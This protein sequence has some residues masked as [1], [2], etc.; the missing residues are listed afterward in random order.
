M[1]K[2]ASGESK[3]AWFRKFFRE[4]P[5]YI[6]HGSNAEVLELWKKDHGGREPDQSIKNVMANVK[7]SVKAELGIKGRGKKRGRKPA[8]A[9][10]N[11]A[12]VAATPAVPRATTMKNLESLEISIDDC[13]SAARRL[14]NPALDDALK[15]LRKARN[16]V[17]WQQGEPA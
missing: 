1:G 14:A 10:G 3:S 4:N 9:A 5:D 13:I 2:K 6:R 15:H 12:E 11:G 17:V 7:S 8:A 16:L